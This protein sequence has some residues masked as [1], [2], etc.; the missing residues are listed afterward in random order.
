MLDG[1]CSY[2]D[3]VAFLRR[4]LRRYNCI[5]VDGLAWAG[6][7]VPHIIRVWPSDRWPICLDFYL[8]G[9]GPFCMNICH[10]NR[11][12][13]CIFVC[14]SYCYTVFHSVVLGGGG[15]LTCGGGGGPVL[16]FSGFLRVV[17]LSGATLVN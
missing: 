15:G 3:Q 2:N 17:S 7:F 12:P 1:N 11:L 13:V 6:C 9:P 5:Y 10:S 14:F 4:I 16:Q 8:F